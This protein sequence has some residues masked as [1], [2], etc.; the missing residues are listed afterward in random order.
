MKFTLSWLK[1]HLETEADLETITDTLTAL[2]LEVEEVVDQGASLAPFTVASVVKAEKHPDADKLQVCQVD[3]GNGIEQVV[4][5]APN[6]RTGMKGV[7]ARSGLTVPGNGMLLKPTKIRGVE[8]NGMLV[9]ER[10]MGLS[11]AHEGIIE[12][13][14]DAEL[15]VP[16]ARILGLDDPMIEIAITPNRQDCLGVRG[17]ARDLAAAG[18]GTLKPDPY[19]T[20]PGTFASPVSIQLKLDDVEAPACPVFTG[21]YIRGVRNGPSPDWMQRRLTAIGLRPI[22][23]L[24]DVTNYLSYDRA[25]PLHVYDADKLAGDIH[26]RIAKTGETMLALDEKDYTLAGEECVIADDSGPIALGGV[27]GGMS[28]GCTEETTNVVLESAL[29][30]PLRT[31]Y[32]GRTLNI[33]SDAR[34]RFERGV[35][36]AYVVGGAEAATQLILDICGGEVSEIVV[37]GAVPDWGH[38]IDLRPTRVSALAGIDVSAA[39]SIRILESLGFAAEEVGGVIQVQVPSWRVDI[40]GEADLVEE[41]TRVY[42]YNAIPS[43]PLPDL[44]D[45]PVPALDLSQRRVRTVRRLLASRGLNEAI[46]WSF[47]SSAYAALFGGGDAATVLDNPISSELDAMRPSMLPGLLEAAGR[48][49]D[50]GFDAAELFEVGPQFAGDMPEDQS[51]VAAGVRALLHHRRHWQD[52]PVPQLALDAKADALTALEAVGAPVANLRVSTEAPGWYHPGRSGALMLGPKTVLAHFGEVHP[53]IMREMDVRGHA[54]AFEIYLDNVPARAR[55]RTSRPALNASDL[56]AVERD[57]AFVVDQEIAAQDL[58][59]AA[60]SADKALIED[61]SLFD[62]YEGE[63]LG[64]G[65]KS[66]AICVRLQPAEKTLTDEEIDAVANKVVTAVSKAT[67]GTLRG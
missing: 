51:T 8:S 65:K 12:M 23:A 33:D 44:T 43:V 48:N 4:C 59:A 50:R 62:L 26:V 49:M 10:E 38:T 6:A 17:I 14:D 27:M 9:S 39:E 11:D 64:D 37:A 18:L 30:D 21:R 52:A 56:P 42:G 22:S 25:R 2:G 55:K 58:L 13:P 34:Y 3:T 66:L 45:V 16:F 47:V 32:T 63:G 15:G 19:G 54:G 36:S 7:F 57:F 29:F 31:A 61:V 53:R 46:T 28:T 40:E 5:G 41:V 20:V 24:V 1:D 60:R 35:D 67:G